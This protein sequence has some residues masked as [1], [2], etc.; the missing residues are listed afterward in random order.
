[1]ICPTTGTHCRSA[2]PH[3]VSSTVRGSAWT[4]GARNTSRTSG[5]CSG[6]RLRTYCAT[7]QRFSSVMS[8]FSI[9]SWNDGIGVPS[10]PV[11]I[12]A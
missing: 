12:R 1:M 3:A 11:F 8:L 2:A 10:S 6:E 4:R 9:D 7:C 5:G